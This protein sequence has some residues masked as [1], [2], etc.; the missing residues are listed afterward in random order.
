MWSKTLSNSVYY[1]VFI[2][3]IVFIPTAL[4]TFNYPLINYTLIYWA[5]FYSL[6]C[7][8]GHF[9][10]CPMPKTLSDFS[11][12]FWDLIDCLSSLQYFFLAYSHMIFSSDMLYN[13]TEY[14]YVIE[15]GE[16][17]LWLKLNCGK[18]RTDIFI[19]LKLPPWICCF[20]VPCYKVL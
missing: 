16:L 1:P 9:I 8:I 18:L 2:Y 7:F 3:W 13:I 11:L 15:D 4:T 20:S 14:K 6:H 5:S 10:L 12:M 19:I 17:R